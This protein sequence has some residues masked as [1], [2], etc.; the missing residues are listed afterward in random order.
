MRT[1]AI[2]P[3]KDEEIK[4][5]IV[6][7]G[8]LR[9][10]KEIVDDVIV[11][12]DGSSDN[13]ASVAKESGATVISHPKNKGVGAAIRTGIVYA[14]QKNYDICVVMGGDAQDDPREINRVISPIVNGGYDFVQGSR[15]HG[16]VVNFPI[17]RKI[18]T[19]LFNLFFKIVAGVRITD[20]S[21]GYRAFRTKI[22][23]DPRINLQ[24]EWLN[25][26]EL[27]P[28]LFLQTIK[29]GYKVKEVPVTKM[30]FK[31]LGYSKMKPILSWWHILRPLITEFF[32]K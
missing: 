25:R 17:F 18:T 8:V 31:E 23:K 21:N 28:Y 30:Y 24:Q 2:I 13:T 29:R 3:A 16:T 14:I 15:V 10:A 12:D 26:Y 5:G 27:E 22:V 1:I 9:H 11:V 19:Y 6:V 20:A 4:I 32:R 7:S